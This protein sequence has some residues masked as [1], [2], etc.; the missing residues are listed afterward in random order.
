MEVGWH[1]DGT[2]SFAGFWISDT[3]KRGTWKYYHA[4]GKLRVSEQYVEGKRVS[5]SCFDEQG[6]PIDPAICG[7]EEEAEF[8]GGLNAWRRFIQATLNPG[9]P[10][11]NKAPDGYYTVVMQFIV[12]TDGKISDIKPRTHFG[13]GM[14]EEAER[15]LQRSPKWTPA[16]QHGRTVKAY[17]LQPLTFV[18]E[19]Q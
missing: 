1:E 6:Q 15:M 3:V 12:G 17:R 4:N 16:H 13:F 18:V 5:A 10:I 19:T 11:K 14:E 2:P 9:V 7:K 8:P